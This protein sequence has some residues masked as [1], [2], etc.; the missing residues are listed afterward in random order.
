MGQ[1]HELGVSRKKKMKIEFSEIEM[2][3]DFVSSDQPLMNVAYVSKS[4]GETYIH[5][6]MHGEEDDLPDDI[7][8]SD[9]YI[10]IPHKNDLDLGQKLVWKFVER[11]IPGLEHKVRGFFSRR[12]AYSRYKTFLEQIDLLEKWYDYENSE[13]QKALRAWCEENEIETDG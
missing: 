8:E 11:E 4:R 10:E 3:F 5:S 7:Y 1:A 9:D 12:E 2:A 6:E 13:T